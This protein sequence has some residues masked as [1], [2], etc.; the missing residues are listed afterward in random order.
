MTM[1]LPC[2]P[3]TSP[4]PNS[5]AFTPPLNFQLLQRLSSI[6]KRCNPYN[7]RKSIENQLTQFIVCAVLETWGWPQIM[8]HLTNRYNIR[9]LPIAKW[10]K[11]HLETWNWDSFSLPTICH[12][13]SNELN[14][15][16]FW[17]Y[18][19]DSKSAGRGPK[20]NFKDQDLGALIWFIVI[21]LSHCRRHFCARKK[22]NPLIMSI[23]WGFPTEKCS[24]HWQEQNFGLRLK[25]QHNKS[26]GV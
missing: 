14:N 6:S 10:T 18:Q 12:Y 21:I 8:L 22:L 13:N 11:W 25:Y 26:L 2:V 20:T 19:T 4:R 17:G 3:T 1:M 23:F 7:E 9:T 15:R 24:F 16:A 5:S